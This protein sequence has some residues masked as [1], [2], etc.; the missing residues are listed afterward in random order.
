MKISFVFHAVLCVL[1]VVPLYS[2][3]E[4]V[5]L[6]DRPDEIV[7]Q[8]I[9]DDFYFNE[10]ETPEEIQSIIS[11][12]HA[13]P[14]ME[15]G[16]PDLPRMVRSLIIPDNEVMDVKVISAKYREI[17]SVDVAPSKGYFMRSDNPDEIPYEYGHWYQ[18]DAFYPGQLARLNDPY[19]LRDFRGQTLDIYPFQYNPVTRVLRVYTEI[20][21]QLAPSGEPGPNV[22]NRQRLTETIHREFHHV[23]KRQFLNY[24]G[25]RYTPLE[26]EG[27]MLV[28][29][30]DDFVDA[31][32]PFV[33]WK[34]T[35]GQPTVLVPVS[36][37]GTT[38]AQIKSYI[39]DYYQQN[40]LVY[41]LFVGDAE[42]IP[43]YTQGIIEG[44]SD[45]AYGYLKGDDRYQEVFVGRFSAE[46]ISHVETLVQRTLEY[47]QALNMEN[48]WLNV[49]MGIARSEG[50][51]SG[52]NGGESD[53]E[54]MDIIRNNLLTHH[55]THVHQ[56]YD[57]QYTW[58]DNP[59]GVVPTSA[60]QISQ[61]I[62]AGAG[63]INYCNHGS[64]TGWSVAG[65]NASHVN[66][67]T[68]SGRLPFVW[69]VACVNGHFQGQTCFAETW[70][71]ATHAETG[72]PT[73]ALAFFGSTINQPWHP[74]MDAQ[75][76]FNDIL[77]GSYANNI[78]RTFGGISVN[79]VF[80]M[81]D[82][83]NNEYGHKTAETWTI[84]GDPSVKI[85]TDNP[86]T[87]TVQHSEVILVGSDYL[88]LICDTE[89]ALAALTRDGQIIST[90]TVQDGSVWLSLDDLEPEDELTIA[91]TSYNKVPYLAQ[92]Q[93]L[94]DGPYANFTAEPRTVI[95]GQTVTFTD[96][97]G[98]GEFISW[99]WDFGADADPSVAT[100]QGPH[101]VTYGT[102]GSKTI[103]L[104]VDDTWERVKTDYV[105]VADV[106]NLNVSVA[107]S[108]QILVDGIPYEE[109]MQFPENTTVVLEANPASEWN[110]SHWTGHLS[111]N[112][113]P[114]NLLMD[115]N[116]S[117]HAVFVQSVTMVYTEGDIATDSDFT[118]LPGSSACPGIMTVSVPSHAVITGV[119]VQYTMSTDNLGWMAEQRSQLRCVS[120][121][122]T[123]ETT[124]ASGEG[125]SQ[126]AYSYHRAGLDIANGV[127]GGGELIFELHAGRTWSS[128][129]FSGCNTYHNKVDNGSWSVTV[130]YQPHEPL[131][132]DVNGDGVQNIADVVMLINHV[133]GYE[134][135]GF[136]AGNADVTGNGYVNEEDVFALV[137]IVLDQQEKCADLQIL[138]N[139]IK[140]DK[141]E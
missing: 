116:K 69:S 97:S 63:V 59:C 11:A 134:Q 2:Q 101:E 37:V 85:R 53:C 55:Y 135:P 46:N 40:D 25:S 133:L 141:L 131:P 121:G 67:L 56:D 104:W 13:Y 103:S 16:A 139:K 52:H 123:S 7:L 17:Q 39:A 50:A 41:V 120:P 58:Q 20:T 23:Y 49:A 6:Q 75:D 102:P 32:Q 28:I 86:Q 71:R 106:A 94:V 129:G 60:A 4:V 51:G 54:H 38:P 89:G 27:S 100:G 122:G 88:E 80:K 9:V 107:G 96:T 136:V 114:V 10:T 21:L 5:L 76:E 79:G 68:N 118:T 1:C 34:N 66:A 137:N 26:E 119:D 126:G 81:L 125:N 132:G 140:Q 84:F 138:M 92:L 29:C 93:V 42:Q 91:V 112:D 113:N 43:V 14:V 74:P 73:G 117:V 61:R 105:Q 31:M 70:T 45:N 78:K 44:Y 8:L 64:V 15:K 108:G 109:G 35:I 24:S 72:Q 124:L 111:G 128:D 99:S 65:Y 130:Y 30:Y 47:E 22:Y 127:I 12:P 57:K 62:N 110:F 48:D 90:A 33:H 95:P 77:I 36:V 115:A 3:N 19:I 87:M 18:E 83:N 98:G 82:L